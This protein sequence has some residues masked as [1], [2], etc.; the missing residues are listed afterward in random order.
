MCDAWSN[1]MLNP[2]INRAGNALITGGMVC[3]SLWQLA[4][5]PDFVLVNSA[6]WQA[7]Q[8]SCPEKVNF[9]VP[10]SRLWQESQFV[11][12]CSG[13]LCENAPYVL[14]EIRS[15]VGESVFVAV[16]VGEVFRVCWRQ[17]AA[18][19]TSAAKTRMGLSV[20]FEKAGGFIV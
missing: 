11:S 17:L 19:I 2:S 7:I 18:N 8:E 14:P 13:T 3:R 15:A 16:I 4:Q 1:F 12:L 5:I 10:L 6:I 20:V 9:V